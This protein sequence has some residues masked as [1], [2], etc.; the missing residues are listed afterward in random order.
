MLL[1]AATPHD[2]KEWINALRLHQID[3]IESR[4]TFFERKLQ[5]A[6]VRVPRASILITQGF[7]APLQSVKMPRTQSAQPGELQSL[8]ASGKESK[9]AVSTVTV[10]AAAIDTSSNPGLRRTTMAPLEHQSTLMVVNEDEE[11][12][13]E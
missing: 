12:A 13:K 2:M 5:R 6:G 3:V 1:S 11:E 10:G 7:N 8:M 4:A 9:S